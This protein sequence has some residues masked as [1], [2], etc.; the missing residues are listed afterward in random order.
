MIT[1]VKAEKKVWYCLMHGQPVATHELAPTSPGLHRQQRALS[2]VCL[3]H[4]I[5]ID[6]CC[7]AACVATRCHVHL[8]LCS[9]MPC[10]AV[11]IATLRFR[12]THSSVCPQKKGP[13]MCIED[14]HFELFGLKLNDL[15]RSP[16]GI[17]GSVM[18]VKYE[19]HSDAAQRQGAWLTRLCTRDWVLE[20]L[21][22]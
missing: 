17:V 2:H 1:M 6:T 15:V 14:E 21:D 19:S 9:T 8:M 10:L 4:R 12:S 13:A 7:D 16:V 11:L 5:C 20:A 18:G 3:L 22:S